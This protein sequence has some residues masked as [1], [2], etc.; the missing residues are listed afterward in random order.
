MAPL[1][2]WI[3]VSQSGPLKT[4]PNLLRE[5]GRPGQQR[6]PS[7]PEQATC[8]ESSPTE[9]ARR[10]LLR[11]PQAGPAQHRSPGCW[12]RASSLLCESLQEPQAD[13]FPS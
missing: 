10:L 1:V 7:L 3:S 4:E 13:L 5:R 12:K 11:L 8:L 2:P 9:G 6:A